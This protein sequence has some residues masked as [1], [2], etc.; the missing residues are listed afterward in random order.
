MKNEIIKCHICNKEIKDIYFKN[1]YG[2][3]LCE[4]CHNYQLKQNIKM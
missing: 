2:S 4:K 1:F 3:Y